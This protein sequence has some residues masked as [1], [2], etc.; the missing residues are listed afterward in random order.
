MIIFAL[1][2]AV[3]PPFNVTASHQWSMP[4]T[5][6]LWGA[7]ASGNVPGLQ[8]YVGKQVECFTPKVVDVAS[9]P[10]IAAFTLGTAGA[11]WT[12]GL[13]V[14]HL[15]LLHKSWAGALVMPGAFGLT[16]WSG[17]LDRC[18][19][20]PHAAMRLLSGLDVALN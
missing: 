15:S 3:L 9:G 18:S 2:A 16:Q 4:A 8:V 14:P 17:V 12:G 20:L 1:T 19:G 13:V 7:A 10:N 6:S 11:A 5:V